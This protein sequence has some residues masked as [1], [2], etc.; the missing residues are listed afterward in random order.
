MGGHGSI[1]T[2][3]IIPRHRH[4]LRFPRLLRRLTGIAVVL[5]IWQLLSS[6]GRLPQTIVGSPVAVWDQGI[7]LA[8]NGELGAAI[9]AS[10]QR[11]GAGLLI[12]A[13]AGI[14][15]ALISGLSRLGEDIFDAPMQMLRT[16]P[17]VGIIPLLIIWLGVGQA[18][19]VALIALGVMFPVYINL[20]AGIRAVDPQLVEA[21]RAMGLGRFG[22]IWHVI[23]PSALPQL[24]VGLRFALGIAW[25]ALIFA[26]QISAVNG[27]G[28]LMESAQELL[29]SNT[30]VVCLVVY[31]FLGLAAD[32]IVRGLERLLLSWR[33][34]AVEGA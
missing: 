22:I 7:T 14:V 33:P 19:K 10:L 2:E 16:V 11:V 20:I 3:R 17:F 8:S 9:G 28:Y 18:P 21:G 34:R 26:E 6:T 13:C 29:Q 30:I 23:L 24:L 4:R 15:L 5:A 27:L 31:A 1:A 32:A 25:L 12:G